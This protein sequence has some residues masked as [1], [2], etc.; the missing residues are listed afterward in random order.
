MNTSAKEYYEGLELDKL[1]ETW[2]DDY[3]IEIHP[4]LLED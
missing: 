4:E 3:E 2:K 1:I